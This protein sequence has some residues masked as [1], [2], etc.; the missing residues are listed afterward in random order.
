MNMI[1]TICTLIWASIFCYFANWA[2]DRVE[3]N[4]DTVYDLNWR[5]YPVDMQKYVVLMLARS[6]ERIEFNG[7]GLAKCTLESFGKVCN[8]I[9]MTHHIKTKMLLTM[10]IANII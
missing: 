8:I 7:L 9:L 1:G 2:S 6:Q 5:D 4:G 3:E 10:F